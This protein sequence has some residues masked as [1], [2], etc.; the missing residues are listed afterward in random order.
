MM[1]RNIYFFALG[2]LLVY[3]F[4]YIVM[5]FCMVSAKG[6]VCLDRHYIA[7]PVKGMLSKVFVSKSD[8]VKKGDSLAL[9][10][11]EEETVRDYGRDIMNLD[12]EADFI[13]NRISLL[14]RQAENRKES[15]G[16]IKK[17][18]RLQRL[19]EFGLSDSTLYLHDEMKIRE[20]ELEIEALQDKHRLIKKHH[21][22]LL[23][24]SGSEIKKMEYVIRA[25]TDGLVA[26]LFR[27]DYGAVDVNDPLMIL[28]D[29]SKPGRMLA[30]FSLDD[31][32]HV[33]P[34][35]RVRAQLPDGEVLWTR[36]AKFYSASIDSEKI[37]F[38]DGEYI[39]LKS[40]VVA[41]LV[42]EKKKNRIS[43]CG[44]MRWRSLSA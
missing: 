1:T 31:M 5:T 38:R 40:R 32:K 10:V 34:G 24:K 14:R 39:P 19:L 11:V 36:I 28:T 42:P 26:T 25:P 27:Q 17:Q 6:T 43:G 15:L 2:G 8:S 12:K 29:C 9:V 44:I 20:L 33:Q 37:K 41:E 3:L 21:D 13:A 30:Y 7:S 22:S 16:A 18:N 35:R 4:S 23:A